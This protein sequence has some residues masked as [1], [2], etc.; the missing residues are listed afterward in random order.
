MH[1]LEFNRRGGGYVLATHK[2]GMVI[3]TPCVQQQQQQANCDTVASPCIVYYISIATLTIDQAEEPE[4]RNL[5][6]AVKNIPM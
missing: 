6:Q 2:P 5:A 1:M 3:I 4:R